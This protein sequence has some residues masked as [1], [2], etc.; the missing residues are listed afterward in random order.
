MKPVRSV[1]TIALLT[2]LSGC[3]LTT[4]DLEQ[5]P[6]AEVAAADPCS[7]DLDSELC[8]GR[9]PHPKGPAKQFVEPTKEA[10]KP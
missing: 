3:A 7:K 9:R 1:I 8:V 10:A 4:A 5:K 6:R 2:A